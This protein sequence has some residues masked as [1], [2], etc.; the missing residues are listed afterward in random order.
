MEGSI[1]LLPGKQSSKVLS[2]KQ[3]GDCIAGVQ[4]GIQC[5]KRIHK[6]NRRINR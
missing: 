3:I 4:P 6:G 5:P 2:Q 1:R